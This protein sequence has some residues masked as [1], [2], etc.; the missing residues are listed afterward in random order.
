VR[1]QEAEAEAEPQGEGRD[2]STGACRPPEQQPQPADEGEDDEH[3]RPRVGP[4]GAGAGNEVVEDGE[5]RGGGAAREQ[6][7][8]RGHRDE[9]PDL[10]MAPRAEQA[11]HPADE[12][13]DTGVE[14]VL[15][16]EGAAGA[17]WNDQGGPVEEP[18][19]RAPRGLQAPGSAFCPP[20]EEGSRSG[21]GGAATT[22][23]ASW[24]G[25]PRPASPC[26]AEAGRPQHE[27][28]RLA[29]QPRTCGCPQRAAGRERG[30]APTRP[31]DVFDHSGPR[32]WMGR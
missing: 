30:S 18:H 8:R 22:A 19:G 20:F 31:A 1:G 28:R 11:R 17:V 29:S 23:T 13:T 27:N 12:D 21:P 3:G 25:R 16:V 15:P 32:G 24:R 10:G 6:G 4:E 2:R 26:G 9:A 5:G 7:P 14:V